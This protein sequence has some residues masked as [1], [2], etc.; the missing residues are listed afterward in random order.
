MAL[1]SHFGWSDTGIS[2]KGNAITN[3]DMMSTNKPGRNFNSEL[4]WRARMKPLR[5][6]IR[7]GVFCDVGNLAARRYPDDIEREQHALHPKRGWLIEDKQHPIEWL[8]RGAAGQP[9]L[10]HGWRVGNLYFEPNA[11]NVDLGL[12][13]RA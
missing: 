13:M 10:P 1:R 8:E 2:S 4:R 3:A 12:V 7:P 6:G 11:A 5:I 9:A